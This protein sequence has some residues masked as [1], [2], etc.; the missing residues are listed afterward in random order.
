M[1]QFY[2]QAFDYLGI[3]AVIEGSVFCVHG[4]LSPDIKTLDQIN[5]IER[6]KEPPI[7]G[8]PLSDLLWSDP[9]DGVETWEPSPRGAGWLFGARVTSHFNQIN[10]LSLIA[11]GH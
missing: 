8:G 7:E 4:G 11:R 9:E 2:C 1:W 10:D 3:S 6:G 5:L